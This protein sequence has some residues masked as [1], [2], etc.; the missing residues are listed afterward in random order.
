MGVPVRIMPP[1]LTLRR[2]ERPLAERRLTGRHAIL[3]DR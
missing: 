1:G 3:G 2:Y